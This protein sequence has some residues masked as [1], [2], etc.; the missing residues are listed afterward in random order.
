MQSLSSIRLKSLRA[1]SEE[2]EGAHELVN[3]T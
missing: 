3:V 2:C 1:L